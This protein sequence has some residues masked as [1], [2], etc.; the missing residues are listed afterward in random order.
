MSKTAELC[1]EAVAAAAAASDARRR[2]T[3]CS[4]Y[5]IVSSSSSVNSVARTHVAPPLIV[6]GTNF[7]SG[8]ALLGNQVPADGAWPLYGTAVADSRR[9]MTGDLTTI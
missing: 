9:R 3:R 7:T 4:R 1:L 6:S 8:T 2:R 5:N